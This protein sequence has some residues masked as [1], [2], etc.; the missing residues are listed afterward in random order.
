MKALDKT[1][2]ASLCILASVL[3]LAAAAADKEGSSGLM[4]TLTIVAVIGCI[5]L[6][7]A[8]VWYS[9]LWLVQ[10]L[11]RGLGYGLDQPGRTR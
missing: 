3:P 1:Y 6:V 2:A 7:L 5:F 4:R 10:R 8:A 9:V 11:K